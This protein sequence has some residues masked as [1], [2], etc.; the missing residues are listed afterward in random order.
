MDVARQ[1][2]Q[3]WRWAWHRTAHTAQQGLPEGNAGKKNELLSGASLSGVS[4]RIWRNY[5]LGPNHKCWRV[6][7]GVN[8]IICKEYGCWETSPTLNYR[9]VWWRMNSEIWISGQLWN[10]LMQ[11]W[12]KIMY[13]NCSFKNL[14]KR[15]KLKLLNCP[16]CQIQKMWLFVIALGWWKLFM[17]RKCWESFLKQI[18]TVGIKCWRVIKGILS[19][20][21]TCDF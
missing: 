12:I 4:R 17:S 21:P 16:H 19:P 18:V 3:P 15:G 5:I 1:A 9:I 13:Y 7:S 8:V 2:E 10:R 11:I 6:I 14:A 20:N